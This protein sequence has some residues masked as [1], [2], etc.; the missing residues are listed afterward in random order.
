MQDRRVAFGM[1]HDNQQEIISM[2]LRGLVL[3]R[4]EGDG[5]GLT[6]KALDLD[7]KGPIIFLCPKI[8]SITPALIIVD[9]LP[10]ISGENLANEEL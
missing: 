6:G 8:E 1:L 2:M 4:R 9:H 5:G 7:D 3:Q 10:A